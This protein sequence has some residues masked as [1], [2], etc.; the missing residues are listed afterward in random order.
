MEWGD[1]KW[2]EDS[3]DQT[4]KVTTGDFA[5]NSNIFENDNIAGMD[6]MENNGYFNKRI[7]FKTGDLFDGEKRLYM[8]PPKKF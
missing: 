7:G 4:Y 5:H 2:D 6:D 3:A 8:A 1:D